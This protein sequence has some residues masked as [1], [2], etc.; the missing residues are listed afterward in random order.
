MHFKV[1]LLLIQRPCIFQDIHGFFLSPFKRSEIAL[2]SSISSRLFITRPA[3]RPANSF[4]CLVIDGFNLRF[5]AFKFSTLIKVSAAEPFSSSEMFTLIFYSKSTKF[6][7][8]NSCHLAKKA[9]RQQT[10]P[11]HHKPDPKMT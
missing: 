8:I 1:F 5:P 2:I 4:S 11:T 3:M 7:Q 9:Q 6:P 10:L